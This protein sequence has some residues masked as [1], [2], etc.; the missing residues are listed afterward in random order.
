MAQENNVMTLS[1][2]RNDRTFATATTSITQDDYVFSTEDLE[3]MLLDTSRR[4]QLE[5]LIIRMLRLLTRNRFVS[6]ATWQEYFSREWDRREPD[7]A[8]PFYSIEKSPSS[9]QL[10][11][12]K[13]TTMNNQDTV[14]QNETIANK[15][16]DG[17]RSFFDLPTKTRL[18]LLNTLCEWQLDDP[19]R[20]REHMNNEEDATQ[21]VSHSSF[22]SKKL[23]LTFHV[24]V[25]SRGWIL[26]VMTQR[27]IPFGSLMTI[28]FTRKQ[29][30]SKKKAM[31]RKKKKSIP[32]STRRNL[33]S[34][35]GIST[36]ASEPDEN[37]EEEEDEE[38]WVPWKLVCMTVDE[39]QRFPQKY[40][41]SNHTQ[42]QQF[43]QLLIDDVLPKVIPVIEE[44]E[45]NR[46]KQEAL[47]YRK[48]SSR[49][50]V[51]EL[52]ALEHHQAVP[53]DLSS[54]EKT[55]SRS[56]QRRLQKEADEKERQVKA[57]EERILERE[58]KLFAK[59][60]AEERAAEKARLDRERRLQRRHGDGS[61][62]IDID[63]TD[64]LI[65]D[66]ESS[67][68]QDFK[69]ILTVADPKKK[70]KKKVTKEI[71][72]KK[73]ADDHTLGKRKRGRKPKIRLQ[74]DDE[75]WIF[76][77][78]CGVFGK[79]IDDGSPM[80]ACER[81]NEW[82]HIECLRQSGQVDTRLKSF[83]N[84]TF[85]C[86]RCMEKEIN[87]GETNTIDERLINTKIQK[88]MPISSNTYT[89][90]SSSYATNTSTVKNN[91]SHYDQSLPPIPA[92]HSSSYQHNPPL[93]VPAY[94]PIIQSSERHFLQQPIQSP[95]KPVYPIQPQYADSERSSK[96]LYSNGG[97]T[98]HHPFLPAL[99]ASMETGTTGE[100]Q[101]YHHQQH[102]YQPHQ[103]TLPSLP[104]P[105]IEL[106][107]P[108]ASNLLSSVVTSSSSSFPPVTKNTNIPPVNTSMTNAT[109]PP[110]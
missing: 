68:Q 50:L 64:D 87:V 108:Q 62:D 96:L 34:S 75:S 21:W 72:K 80:I 11:A 46:K 35:R 12:S 65:V 100:R 94:P 70:Y 67:P 44:H 101:Q 6:T 32:Q 16:D 38:E 83:D 56:E 20:L 22:L 92:S 81:C 54:Q 37:L 93:P 73:G 43:H 60:Q 104:H 30:R 8:N 91:A 84:L 5:E 74:E 61:I 79:N 19:E 4:Y 45:K 26:L 40:A 33:R 13:A 49:I 99:P 29:H 69:I 82:Q 55:L 10:T 77:C 103:H 109:M 47:A 107:S 71:K 66:Q 57:R 15:S 76:N 28:D 3:D 98:A 86:R 53:N 63:D 59:A 23:S 18:I 42:D 48:R 88:A 24:F 25:S 105:P 97:T 52:E 58:R 27:G 7:E 2:L 14:T 95:F 85:I 41:K 39:W 102:Y 78:T 36:A 31:N 106:E 9:L 110:Q 17:S 90:P 1:S 51:R 89:E